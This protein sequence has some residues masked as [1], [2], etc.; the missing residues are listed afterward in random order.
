MPGG[1]LMRHR[2]V[3]QW[4]SVHRASWHQPRADKLRLLINPVYGR[5]AKQQWSEGTMNEKVA[6]LISDIRNKSM[7]HTHTNYCILTVIKH[8]TDILMI[9]DHHQLEQAAFNTIFKLSKLSKSWRSLSTQM[10]LP[11]TETRLTH[12]Y[13]QIVCQISQIINININPAS[14]SS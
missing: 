12:W 13:W 9:I 10:E 4:K 14:Q 8:I 1:N 11:P 2:K 7:L 5:G 6:H 3:P